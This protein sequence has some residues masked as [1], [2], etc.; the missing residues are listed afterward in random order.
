M[1]LEVRWPHDIY[2]PNVV[3]MITI[4]IPSKFVQM[5]K[6]LNYTLKNI[7]DKKNLRHSTKQCISQE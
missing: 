6:K 3:K 4:H 7:A 1:V 2:K 5:L